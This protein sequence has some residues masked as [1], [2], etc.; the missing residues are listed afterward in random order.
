VAGVLRCECGFE[1]RAA[2]ED[3]LVAEVRRHAWQAHRTAL[4]HTDALQL[5][6]R[7][8]APIRITDES[9]T[10]LPQEET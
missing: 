4:S 6:R 7:T 9:T 3:G 8:Q 5:T 10:S 2:D 1:A